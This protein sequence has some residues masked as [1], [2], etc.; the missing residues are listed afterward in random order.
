MQYVICNVCNM[1]YV[2]CNICDMQ[3]WAGTSRLVYG[4]FLFVT[5][6]TLPVIARCI[7]THKMHLNALN[8][9]SLPPSLPSLSSQVHSNS[10]KPLP[11]IFTCILYIV[12]PSQRGGL[13][14]DHQQTA[15]TRARHCLP[16]QTHCKVGM[17]NIVFFLYFQNILRYFFRSV[18][19]SSSEPDI[20]CQSPFCFSDAELSVRGIVVEVGS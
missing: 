10:H 11:S 1:Q 6:F 20:I 2:I 8:F 9:K 15:T 12:P 5:Q 16:E 14:Q 18:F 19:T 17:T 4:L 7:Q 13:P 3:V